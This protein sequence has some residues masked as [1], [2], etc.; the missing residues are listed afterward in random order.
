MHSKKRI[1][2]L[3]IVVC[4]LVAHD[5]AWT[6]AINCQDGMGMWRELVK[7]VENTLEQYSQPAISSSTS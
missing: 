6:Q 1:V 7:T 4:Y 3:T 5:N 2:I